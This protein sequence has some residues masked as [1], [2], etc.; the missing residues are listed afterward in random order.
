MAQWSANDEANGAVLWAPAK[1]KKA[2]NTANRDALYLNATADAW[3]TGQ[4][5]GMYGVDENEIAVG[6]QSLSAVVLSEDGTEGSY[7][8]GEPLTFDQTGATYTTAAN[9]EVV[10]TKIREANV[11]VNE[12]GGD[13]AN[14]DLVTTADGQGT[15]AIFVVT[16]GAADTNVASVALANSGVGTAGSYTGNPSLSNAATSN[17]TGTGT[18]LTLD[19]EMEID[20][21]NITSA[22]DYTVLPTTLIDNTLA[23]SASGNGAT[24]NLTFSSHGAG[25]LAHTGWVVRTVGSGGR[26]GRIQTEVL[27]AGGIVTDND[28]DDDVFPDS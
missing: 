14:G 5:I 13:Y 25:T 28:S 4:T 1:Y 19:L 2:P 17:V 11:A 9:L 3:I 27:V 10:T 26:A 8:P 18:G 6:T 21:V 16:T 22:G 23:G 12:P 15:G 24:A 20:T 7:A